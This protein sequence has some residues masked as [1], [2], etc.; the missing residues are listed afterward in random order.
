MEKGSWRLLEHTTH[1]VQAITVHNE[2]PPNANQG[3]P[4]SSVHLFSRAHP[5]RKWG[6]EPSPQ[7]IHGY[8]RVLS[9]LIPSSSGQVAEHRAKH[10]PVLLVPQLQTRLLPCSTK[11]PCWVWGPSQYFVPPWFQNACRGSVQHS[12]DKS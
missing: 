2:S 11:H 1:Q 12:L 4:R 8:T 5:K 3:L 7:S 9:C 10:S 6:A